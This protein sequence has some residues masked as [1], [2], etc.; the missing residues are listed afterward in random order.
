MAYDPK[1]HEIAVRFLDDEP[2]FLN[3]VNI[4]RIA[5]RVQDAIE[6]EIDCI[7]QD[8]EDARNATKEEY[9]EDHDPRFNSR[10]RDEWRF[11]AEQARRLK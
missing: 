6:D 10:H 5:Q 2:D 11:E 7:K 8:A 9:D 3:N 1:C 4:A